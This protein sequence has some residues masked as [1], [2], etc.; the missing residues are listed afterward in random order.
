[1]RI[2]AVRHAWPNPP[3]F[4]MKRPLGHVDFSFVHFTTSVELYINDDKITVPEHACII[5][6]PGTPQYFYCPD[7]MVHDWFHFVDVTPD[8][9]QYFGLL[10]DTLIFPNQWSFITELVEEIENEFY[11]QREYGEELIE[12]K[13][14]ELFI[15][16]SRS[17]SAKNKYDEITDQKTKAGLRQLR[18]EI[19][20]NLSY[21][22]TIAEM[23][24]KLMLSE[25][26]F[27]HVYHA[28]YG[29]SPIDD[30]IQVRINSAQSKLK[31][32]DDPIG[33]IASSLGYRTITHFCRQFRKYVGVSP[34]QYRNKPY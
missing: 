21:N 3:G 25:S 20:G 1:M 19:V 6:N 24:S 10:T 26:R 11:A 27:A 18:A 34:S 31:F 30:V 16:L 17:V 9:F 13:A 2:T 33:E 5:Y 29:T 14:K 23:A 8:F 7:G 22:W 15:K 28:Y 4:F 12:S 32:T